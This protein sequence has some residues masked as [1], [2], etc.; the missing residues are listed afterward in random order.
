MIIGYKVY[1]I[2]EAVKRDIDTTIIP[3][4]P[5]IK[6]HNIIFFKTSLC[7]ITIDF[8]YFTRIRLRLKMI[9][10]KIL[11]FLTLQNYEEDKMI[12]LTKN[13]L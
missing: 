5:S 1:L 12:L 3:I 9:C 13:Y 11:M 10:E 2:R 6:I 4:K 8:H 7:M